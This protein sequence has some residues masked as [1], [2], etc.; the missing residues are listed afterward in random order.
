MT[1]S[2]DNG[3]DEMKEITIKCWVSK[4]FSKITNIEDLICCVADA[5]GQKGEWFPE[6]WPPKRATITIK[7]EQ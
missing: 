4:E 3:G 2:Y 1:W 7:V 5:R 6:A